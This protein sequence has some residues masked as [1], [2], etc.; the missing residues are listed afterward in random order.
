MENKN[1]V[2]KK[3]DKK[4]KKSGCINVVIVSAGY[5]GKHWSI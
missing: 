4:R 2:N 1:L 3:A 5:N